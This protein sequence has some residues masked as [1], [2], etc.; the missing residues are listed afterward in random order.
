[1]PNNLLTV[2]EFLASQGSSQAWFVIEK[3]EESPTI[4]LTPFLLSAGILKELSLTIPVSAIGSIAPVGP[5]VELNSKMVAVVTISFTGEFGDR[6]S[7]IFTELLQ[8][9]SGQI[10]EL[11]VSVDEIEDGKRIKPMRDWCGWHWPTR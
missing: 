6:Y 10:T 2:D 8:N 7:N 5:M 1:M 4:K 9:R 11:A 3:S